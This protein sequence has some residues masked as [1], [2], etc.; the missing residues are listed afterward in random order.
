MYILIDRVLLYSGGRMVCRKGIE[1]SGCVSSTV[2]V[3]A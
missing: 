1:S 2:N 3:I